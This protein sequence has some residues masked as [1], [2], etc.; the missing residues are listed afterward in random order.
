MMER[1][2][3]VTGG[4]DYLKGRASGARVKRGIKV[5]SMRIN[6]VGK[7]SCS[8]GWRMEPVCATTL[9]VLKIICSMVLASRP[10]SRKDI[11]RESMP[12]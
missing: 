3:R 12:C 8:T 1:R 9:A 6:S 10:A 7:V 2:T 4:L 5:A 11:L